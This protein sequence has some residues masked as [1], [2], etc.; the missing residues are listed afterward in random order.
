METAEGPPWH[1]LR[2]GLRGRCP[3]P[4][5]GLT[6]WEKEKL[7]GEPSFSVFLLLRKTMLTAE[8]SL[9]WPPPTGPSCLFSNWAFV[10]GSSF[11]E[12]LASNFCMLWLENKPARVGP[13]G[14]T[15]WLPFPALPPPS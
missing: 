14:Q 8:R 12:A 1:C 13:G 9:G 3:L 10:S 15:G 11:S 2:G 4:T 5:Q 6:R 7:T